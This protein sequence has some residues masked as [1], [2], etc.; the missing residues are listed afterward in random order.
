MKLYRIKIT[1]LVQGV[2]FR[3][4][5]DRKAA[6]HGISGFVKNEYDGSVYVEACGSEKG[7]QRFCDDLRLGPARSVVTGIHIDSEETDICKGGF[8]IR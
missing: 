6:E 4:Y 1:G 8:Q 5:A 7:L 2:G 3:Y